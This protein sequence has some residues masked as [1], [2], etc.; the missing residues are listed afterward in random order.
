MEHPS[1]RVSRR[2]VRI[3]ATHRDRTRIG[4]NRTASREFSAENFRRA[5]A[6]EL[7]ARSALNAVKFAYRV[8]YAN[9]WLSSS[10][11]LVRARFFGFLAG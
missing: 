7:Q 11:K 6:G 5:S 2:T 4:T 9:R 1:W 10:A 3:H 8:R